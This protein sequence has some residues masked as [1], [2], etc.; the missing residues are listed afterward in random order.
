[1]IWKTEKTALATLLLLGLLAR[2][3]QPADDAVRHM[4]PEELLSAARAAIVDRLYERAEL[5]FNEYI[6][7][8]ESRAE[9]AEGVMGLAEALYEQKDFKGTLK[10]LD[11]REKLARTPDIRAGFIFWRAM[12]VAG[13]DDYSAAL[14]L[15]DKMPA[16]LSDPYFTRRA[17]RLRAR[18]YAKIGDTPRA[19][20]A[21]RSLQSAIT[22]EIE[23]ALNLLDW[24]GVLID[25]GQR[26]DASVILSQ[27]LTDYPASPQAVPG[28]LWLSRIHLEEGRLPEAE[29]LLLDLMARE[30]LADDSRAEACRVLAAVA[31]A[32]TNYT[33]AVEF[34]DRAVKLSA[35][36]VV[37]NQSRLRKARLLIRAGRRDE[38]EAL[39]HEWIGAN[40]AN[41]HA[42]ESLLTWAD[43]LFASGEYEK[44]YREY[45]Y[46]QEVFSDTPGRFRAQMGKGWCLFGLKRHAEAVREFERALS[47]AEGDA[48]RK[49]ALFKIADALYADGEY[50]AARAKYLEVTKL[51]PAAQEA[52]QALYQAA[53]C[54]AEAGQYDAAEKEFHAIEDA[55]PESGFARQA[56]LRI[57]AMK[58]LLGEWEQAVSQYNR[59]LREFPGS[60]HAGRARHRRGMVRYRLG[61]FPGALADFEKVVQEFPGHDFSEQAFYMRG[62][63]HYLMGQSDKAQDICREFVQKFPDSAW[64]PDVLFWLAEYQFN[65]GFHQKAEAGFTGVALR[66]PSSELAD[67]A[68]FWA[69]QSAVLQREYLRAIEHFSKL[70]QNYPESP[71]LVQARFAQGDAL[72]ELGQFAAAILAY[73]EVILKAQGSYTA[74]LARGR[75]GDC[76]FTLGAGDPARY[77]EAIKSYAAL[78]GRADVPVEIS[79]QAEYKLGRCLDKTGDAAGALER[80]LNVIYRYVAQKNRAVGSEAWFTRAA[81]GAAAIRE[82]E[83]QWSEAL[84]IYERIIE[85]QVPAAE[86]ARM[87]IRKL[88]TERWV[89][90]GTD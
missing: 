83:Q 56:S 11:S 54:Y 32:Q 50:T 13:Q 40:T 38:G 42:P 48:D 20:K 73:E 70:V 46:Y 39:L 77:A 78:T 72:S 74:A 58:E 33:R 80:Y 21:F 3:A 59:I 86:E 4:R 63:T 27:L 67:D 88:R 6:D 25:L 28:S 41:P 60:L 12:A 19:V 61:S 44:A 24:S 17:S 75:I 87:R 18:C 71:R 84:R 64:A 34:L 52:P 65:N 89:T 85:E 2:S 69:G 51:F 1:M 62:W 36:P 9:K 8:A 49:Q 22:N 30:N 16:R 29:K 15:L 7:K 10:L 90:P 35:D 82:Q 5:Y 53:E 68:I 31:E 26:G 55:Y 14:A 76:Q 81:F 23:A 47:L 79:L 57:A 43:E 66:Y 45:Q 37:L